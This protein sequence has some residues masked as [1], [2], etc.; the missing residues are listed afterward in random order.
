MSKGNQHIDWVLW[1]AY[2]NNLSKLTGLKYVFNLKWFK[3]YKTVKKKVNA[4]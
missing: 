2:S 3:T 4:D 1:Q